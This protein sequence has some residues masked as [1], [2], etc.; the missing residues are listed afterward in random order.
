MNPLFI[1]KVCQ[2]AQSSLIY[3]QQCSRNNHSLCVSNYAL[4]F[5]AIGRMAIAKLFVIYLA[6]GNCTLNLCHSI[7]NMTIEATTRY[8]LCASNYPLIF[9]TLIARMAINQPLRY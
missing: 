4:I 8:S 3:N 2:H 9:A 6:E 5:V 1:Y 7:G